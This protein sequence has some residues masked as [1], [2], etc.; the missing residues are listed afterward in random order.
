MYKIVARARGKY[1]VLTRQ[2]VDGRLNGGG[3]KFGEMEFD[4]LKGHGAAYILHDRSVIA[5]DQFKSMVCNKCGIMGEIIRPTLANFV[6]GNGFLC[7][8]CG[9]TND[10]T[11][12]STT[13]CYQLFQKE[14]AAMNIKVKHHVQD[15]PLLTTEN[16]IENLDMLID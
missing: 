11:E 13:Y 1:A 5:S 9:Q 4:A 7:R 14:L 16:R 6:E 15:N 12:I 10:A 3:Q 8:A 2:P